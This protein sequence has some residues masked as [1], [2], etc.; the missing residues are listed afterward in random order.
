MP[1]APSHLAAPAWRAKSTTP[2]H[3]PENMDFYLLPALPYNIHMLRQQLVTVGTPAAK[4]FLVQFLGVARMFPQKSTRL[5]SE[6]SPT[7]P[8]PSVPSCSFHATYANKLA[9]FKSQW[10]LPDLSL[11]G[12]EASRA[13]AQL[14]IISFKRS[15]RVQAGCIDDNTSST[16]ALTEIVAT[17]SQGDEPASMCYYLRRLAW[18][19]AARLGPKSSSSIPQPIN[20][21]PPRSAFM[22][23]TTAPVPENRNI[24]SASDACSELALR[25]GR[26]LRGPLHQIDFSVPLITHATEITNRGV[27]SPA[28]RP[29]LSKHNLHLPGPTTKSHSGGQAQSRARENPSTQETSAAT[30]NTRLNELLNETKGLTGTPSFRRRAGGGFADRA[31]NAR[32]ESRA[33]PAKSAY[34]PSLSYVQARFRTRGREVRSTNTKEVN[35]GNT[36]LIKSAINSRRVE[37]RNVRKATYTH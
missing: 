13:S 31:A 10:R 17:R 2:A 1:R 18:N 15:K 23:E 20:S 14:D 37:A 3:F 4:S 25:A 16:R 7:P 22:L 32:P 33:A 21:H 11:G 35:R 29:Q 19:P 36:I 27:Q 28:T 9:A 30:V 6:T 12:P 26:N 5:G 24:N 34:A 8:K